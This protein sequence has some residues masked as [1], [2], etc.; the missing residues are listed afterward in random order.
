MLISRQAENGSKGNGPRK[1]DLKVINKA[2]EDFKR[3]IEFI[4][5]RFEMQMKPM[6]LLPED[7]TSGSLKFQNSKNCVFQNKSFRKWKNS[8]GATRAQE[9]MPM[10]GE[11]SNKLKSN[12]QLKSDK[13]V[14]REKSSVAEDPLTEDIDYIK[15]GVMVNEYSKERYIKGETE[16]HEKQLHDVLKNSSTVTGL[17]GNPEHVTKQ[18]LH[19]ISNEVIIVHHASIESKNRILGKQKHAQMQSNKCTLKIK[20]SKLKADNGNI[21]ED[22][23]TKFNQP[24]NEQIM[25]KYYFMWKNYAFQCKFHQ[26][27]GYQNSLSKE[28]C[29]HKMKIE[30]LVELL[31][32]KKIE[33]KLVVDEDK[34]ENFS[35]TYC[36]SNKIRKISDTSKSIPNE[37]KVSFH[38]KYIYIYFPRCK[39]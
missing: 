13:M 23:M 3:E 34:N 15:T 12:S 4:K 11:Q 35:T 2:I 5:K 39:Y 38:M 29:E 7:N 36:T 21:S 28:S 30:R 26:S 8:V 19:P 31:E 32:K 18:I 27:N 33:Q 24:S 25:S 17:L 22:D 20:Q 37:T 14:S 9:N 16:V 6:E 1:H 10:R